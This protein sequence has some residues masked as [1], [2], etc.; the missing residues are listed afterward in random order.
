MN[1]TTN[2]IEKIC[3]EMHYT[4]KNAEIARLE[5]EL[6]AEKQ[7]AEEYKSIQD[8]RN[9][10]E[11][12]LL[13]ERAARLESENKTL[14]MQNDMFVRELRSRPCVGCV[15]WGTRHVHL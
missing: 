7:K 4:L 5:A 12:N 2:A 14:K 3:G 13:R 9:D 11:L 15:Q 8:M 10:T 1:A 6:R